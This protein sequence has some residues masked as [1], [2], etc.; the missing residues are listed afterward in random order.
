MQLRKHF[1]VTNTQGIVGHM[2]QMLH[3]QCTALLVCVVFFA[4][5]HG[6][7]PCQCLMIVFFL[8]AHT[9]L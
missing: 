7:M 9:A 6:W 4:Y 2:L 8:E 3:A 5:R 1:G